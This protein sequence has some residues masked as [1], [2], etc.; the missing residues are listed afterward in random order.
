[1]KKYIMMMLLLMLPLVSNAG[2]VGV[3][4]APVWCDHKEMSNCQS[5][6]LPQFGD[7][8]LSHHG[9]AVASIIA[10]KTTGVAPNS[11]LVTYDLFYHPNNPWDGHWIGHLTD[12]YGWTVEQS[13]VWHAK[14][15]MGVTVFNQSYGDPAGNID[16][17]MLHLWN[18][19]Q[20]VLFVNAAGNNGKVVKSQGAIGGNVI[21]VGAV[22]GNNKIAPWSNKPGHALKHHWI[23]A[24]GVGVR[25]AVAIPDGYMN[26]SGT[27]FAAPQVTGA[28][29][30]LHDRYPHLRKNPAGT[31]NLILTTA[32]DLGPKGVDATYGYGLLN[33]KRA[34]LGAG[35]QSYKKP[36]VD[37]DV[38]YV[39]VDPCAGRDN[40]F[41]NSF[42]F[43]F[44]P[45][46]DGNLEIP[47]MRYNLT[48]ELSVGYLYNEHN[49]IPS[50]HITKAGLSVTLAYDRVE[51]QPEVYY[52]P[53]LS[54]SAHYL[55]AFELTEKTGLEFSA[56]VPMF[57]FSG[58]SQWDD[59]VMS[60]EESP[61]YEV[62]MR[63]K[64]RF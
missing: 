10:G 45:D 3:L 8:Y 28:V 41:I 64:G 24:K 29:S 55:K 59:E 5:F 34:L 40:C 63:W 60:Y 7:T 9:T 35:K 62:W 13:A 20:D 4:D 25:A 36:K 27:S 39:E 48:P 57:T 56:E 33:I 54:A 42:A 49:Y 2:N 52:S 26:V 14:T 53:M 44:I 11:K 18:S 12:D 23:V 47:N 46:A 61:D 19:N 58:Y 38:P 30:L 21:L 17:H 37:K 51:D 15:H 22:D 31:K 32:T 1:M 6:W 43:Q 16:R 50:V